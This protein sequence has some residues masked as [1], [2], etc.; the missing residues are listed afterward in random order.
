M[1]PW[2]TDWPAVLCLDLWGSH[3]A[4]VLMSSDLMRSFSFDPSVWQQ[5]GLRS[6]E[7][8]NHTLQD[9]SS[10]AF[11]SSQTKN[12]PGRW[13]WSILS[14]WHFGVG[15][16]Y[17]SRSPTQFTFCFWITNQGLLRFS[18]W[19]SVHFLILT[20]NLWAAVC[21]ESIVRV[22]GLHCISSLLKSDDAYCLKT[23]WVSVIHCSFSTLCAA[24]HCGWAEACPL[25][26]CRWSGSH[27]RW[28]QPFRLRHV[29]T[30]KYLS[31]MDDQGLLLMD[32]ERADVKSTAFCFRSSKV[33]LT[34]HEPEL[35]LKYLKHSSLDRFICIWGSEWEC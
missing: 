13:S 29:T 22:D 15:A 19:A 14:K 17:W 1:N 5:P 18:S 35:T 4:A 8:C 16:K 33:R 11:C 24:V 27:I 6:H 12:N 28:G 21:H 26:V 30:G 20:L 7:A 31:M 25:A 2:S 32:K 9:V 10:S 34:A 23:T 3:H